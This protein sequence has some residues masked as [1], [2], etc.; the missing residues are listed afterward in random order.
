[1]CLKLQRHVSIAVRFDVFEMFHL[2]VL[3]EGYHLKSIFHNMTFIANV[4][5]LA[6][7]TKI[8]KFNLPSISVCVCLWLHYENLSFK[9]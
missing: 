1:M 4:Q 6:N 7:V 9:N 3:A 5:R 2:E 8:A